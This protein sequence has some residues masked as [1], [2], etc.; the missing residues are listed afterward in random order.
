[1]TTQEFISKYDFHDSLID[2]VTFD[3]E[4]NKVIL[5]ADFAYWMQEWYIENMPETD[6]L[7]V[8]FN[9]VDNFVCPNDVSWEQISIIQASLDGDS[10]KYVLMNDITD[11]YLEI[12]IKCESV[13]IV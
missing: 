10:I 4:N 7:I 8:V 11:D 13:T 3:R 9:G 2:E 12:I 5:H 6:K 1:M